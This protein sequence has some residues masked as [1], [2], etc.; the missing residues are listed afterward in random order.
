M[1]DTIN[2]RRGVGGGGITVNG[3]VTGSVQIGGAVTGNVQIGDG[4]GGNIY[5]TGNVGTVNID[6]SVGGS[7][8]IRAISTGQI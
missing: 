4:I 5:V 6:G 2:V 3:A 7:N 8:T 1:V